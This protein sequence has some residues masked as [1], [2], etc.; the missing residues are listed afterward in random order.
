M[1]SSVEYFYYSPA[2]LVLFLHMHVHIFLY[3]EYNMG[4]NLDIL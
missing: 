2:L 1:Q 3:W 4:S